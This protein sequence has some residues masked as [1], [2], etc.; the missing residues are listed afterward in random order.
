MVQK[1]NVTICEYKVYKA[2]R[3]AKATADITALV[4][5]AIKE[6]R[7]NDIK[8]KAVLHPALYVYL[9]DILKQK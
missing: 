8:E 9:L 3:D 1:M 4:Q 2:I 5:P 7:S 6:L